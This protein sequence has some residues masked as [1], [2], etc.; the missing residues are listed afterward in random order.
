MFTLKIVILDF[1]LISM[2]RVKVY[3]PLVLVIKL[4]RIRFELELLRQVVSTLFL[5]ASGRAGAASHLSL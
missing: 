2:E 5:S 3:K 1:Y 4:I